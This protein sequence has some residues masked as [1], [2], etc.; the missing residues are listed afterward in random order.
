V[1]AWR[2]STAAQTHLREAE[3][4]LSRNLSRNEAERD[5]RFDRERLAVSALVA[6]AREAIAGRLFPEALASVDAALAFVQQ[7]NGV[8]AADF[9][10]VRAVAEKLARSNPTFTWNLTG[11][12]VNGAVVELAFPHAR[13]NDLSPLRGLA[14]RRLTAWGNRISDGR[15]LRG[16]PLREVNVDGNPLT[17][18]QWLDQSPIED[19][20]MSG[21]KVSDLTVLKKKNLRVLHTAGSAVR[22]VRPVLGLTIAEMTVTPKDLT[23]DALKALRAAKDIQRLGIAWNQMW[24]ASEFWQRVDRGEFK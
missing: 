8:A 2:E 4:N 3:R 19:L 6:Q 13:L 22:D 9:W 11:V 12:V 21:T 14:L 17:D 7:I 1:W 18:I 10:V 5:Q 20:R 16:M 15:P 24:P 23:A